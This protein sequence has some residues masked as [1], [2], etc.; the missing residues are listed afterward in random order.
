MIQFKKKKSKLFLLSKPILLVPFRNVKDL[1]I[2]TTGTQFLSLT[3]NWFWL[4]FLLAP[5]RAIWMLWR[6]VIQPWLSSKNDEQPEGDDKKQK[7][8][9][10]KMKQRQMR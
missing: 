9:E 1:I 7:K 5:A 3:S 10:R 6:S 2:L 4:L 8:L